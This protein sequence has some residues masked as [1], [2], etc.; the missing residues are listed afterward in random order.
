MLGLRT[1]WRDCDM[2][3]ARLICSLIFAVGLVISG[4]V[5]YTV[6]TSVPNLK[7]SMLEPNIENQYYNYLAGGDLCRIEDKLYFN[8]VENTMKY[9][10]V[11]ISSMGSRRVYWEGVAWSAPGVGLPPLY[12]C[13]E[14]IYFYHTTLNDKTK[15]LEWLNPAESVQ[16]T[17]NIQTCS[18]KNN[19]YFDQDGAIYYTKSGEYNTYGNLMKLANGEE[20][21]ILQNVGCFLVHDDF[22]YYTSFEDQA[23]SVR[24]YNLTSNRNRKLFSSEISIISMMICKQKLIFMAEMPNYERVLYMYDLNQGSGNQ[25]EPKEIRLS[26]N[27]YIVYDD[28]VY[29]CSDSGVLVFDLESYDTNVI[30]EQQASTCYI[31]DHQWLYFCDNEQN[32]FRVLQT[33]GTTAFVYG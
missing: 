28:K 10:L 7:I 6:S 18:T 23:I 27:S 19:L 29:I 32:L 16:G 4:I 26:M 15:T 13:N 14:R 2:K 17:T 31:V 3:R 12:A 8:Y 24:E 1:S 11:E 30:S 20:N 33:G 21:L 25:I 5:F 9:G 22:I